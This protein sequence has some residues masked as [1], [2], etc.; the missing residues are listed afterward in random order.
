MSM[1]GD[2]WEVIKLIAELSQEVK[3]KVK[4]NENN[5]CAGHSASN[6][7]DRSSSHGARLRKHRRIAASRDWLFAR[8]GRGRKY[9]HCYG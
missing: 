3:V 9:L 2:V 1:R 7:A 5:F 8:A 4:L 6:G